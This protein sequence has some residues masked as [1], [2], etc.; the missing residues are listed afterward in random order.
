M[1]TQCQLNGVCDQSL[2]IAFILTPPMEH[3]AM[4]PIF[5][6]KLILP[7]YAILFRKYVVVCL[8][9]WWLPWN[10]NLHDP[11]QEI[12][13]M[14]LLNRWSY[15]ADNNECT[16]F[17]ECTY[18]VCGHNS[19]V[20]MSFVPDLMLTELQSWKWNLCYAMSTC[21]P[22]LVI[23]HHHVSKTEYAIPWEC[24]S[25]STCKWNSMWWFRILHIWRLLLCW[26][27]YGNTSTIC[28]AIDQW[29]PV[30]AILKQEIAQ[31][32]FNESN[33]LRW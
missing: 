14:P 2:D 19:T 26:N 18:G 22:M 20:G 16:L 25:I 12:V 9:T 17:D 8:C 21:H 4:I 30:F 33:T 31:I 6:L 13:V 11:E 24:V 3:L 10:W 32:H 15:L 27:M 1:D 5:A 23:I 29:M 7:K 28:T